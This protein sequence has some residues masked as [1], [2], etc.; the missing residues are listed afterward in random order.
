MHTL[1]RFFVFL[2]MGAKIV[3][4]DSP[5][6]QL[7]S[8]RHRTEWNW[9]EYRIA[10]KNT[11]SEI[12]FNPEIRYFA[13]DEMLSATVDY[14]TW[15]FPV[16]VEVAPIG[17]MSIIKLSV[18]AMMLPSDS[19][20]VHFR[21]YK[22]NWSAWN[23]SLD[24]SYQHNENKLE[25][26]YFMAVYDDGR[27]LLWGFDPLNGKKNSDAV[28]WSE[29][30]VN[31]VVQKYMGDT[32]E[33]VPAGRFWLFKDSPL[34]LKERLL[35]EQDGIVRYSVGRYQGK[36]LILFK[37][38]ADVR[39]SYLDRTLGHFYNVIPANDTTP[40]VVEMSGNGTEDTLSLNIGCWP[41]VDMKSC[42]DI[43]KKCGGTNIEYARNVVISGM[44]A[45]S[46]RCVENNRDVYFAMMPREGVLLNDKARGTINLADIQNS[47]EWKTALNEQWATVDWLKGVDYTGEG[48]L[49]GIY[50][51]GVD[52]SHPDFQELDSSGYPKERIM[53][54][55]EYYGFYPEKVRMINGKDDNWHGTSVAGV[56]G[57]NG[58]MS[59]N[60]VYRGVAP[61]VHFYAR[62]KNPYWLIGHVINRSLADDLFANGIY[63]R[64]CFFIDRAIFRN[65]KTDCLKA[66][67]SKPCIEG[68][69][70]AK[71][72]V[73]AAA[74]SGNF[75]GSHKQDLQR[76]YHS[77]LS[78]SKNAITVG[79]ITSREKVRFHNSSM[80]P[81]WDGRIKPDVMAPGATSEML[82]NE[83]HPFELMI[84]YVKLFRTGATAPYKVLDFKDNIFTEDLNNQL[85]SYHGIESAWGA[86]NG[87]VFKIGVN[88][89][90]YASLYSGWVFGG[91]VNVYPTDELEIRM[92]VSKGNVL[93]SMMYGNIILR[94]NDSTKTVRVVWNVKKSFVTTR[95]KL[96]SV[97][98]ILEA[99]SMRLD[100]GFVKGIISPYPCQD[101]GTC[102]YGYISDGGTS[103]SAPQVSG[104]A[105][106][107][108]QKFR[109]CT[110]EP[111]D[112][113][114]MRNSTVKSLIIHSAV[115]MEDSENAHF[116]C[117]PDIT[118]AHH[119][120]MCH[121]TPYG[122]GPDFATGW[123]RIDAAKALDAIGGYDR[124]AKEFSRFK[125]FEIG[126]GM[127][128]RWKVH[129]AGHPEK[130]R[131]TLV[132]DDAPGNLG[133]VTDSLNFLES[134]LVNDLDMYLV[135]P[136]G[137]YYYPWRLDPL[138]TD[139]IDANGNFTD[140]FSSGLENIKVQDVR[141]AY[142]DCNFSDKLD[143]RC[144]DH[145]NNV[146]VVDVENPESGSWQVVVR[147]TRISEGNNAN[148]DAQVA[149]IVSDFELKQSQCQIMHGYSAQSRYVCDYPFEK[150][151]A[152]YITFAESTF[153]G[154]GDTISLYDDKN[155]LLGKYTGNSLAGQ[156]FRVK[157]TR[158]KVVLDSDNDGVQG[159]GFGV[160]KI[161]SIPF[162]IL[163]MP[164]QFTNRTRQ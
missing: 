118:Y 13:K 139:F 39:K 136:S 115:D 55:F 162:A 90:N 48:I 8:E 105:A 161:E 50:D 131:V 156:K 124:K 81:T 7:L 157:A 150:Q 94:E 1:F 69:T 20:E 61:K 102:D 159:W 41:D 28:L 119:D 103:Q 56:I 26:H 71:T 133:V 17:G 45:D 63:L 49:V 57:G 135:S 27:H 160:S 92:K 23:S 93:N 152:N 146:E 101:D 60:H 21:I 16:T 79:N 62:D 82:V 96:N 84:D 19:L 3:F 25:R 151:N 33:F 47:E 78:N 116:S 85:S 164:L 121:F 144:F 142:N 42:I 153:V 15:L 12:I 109:E 52:F 91:I 22:E 134:K 59:D 30:G 74:N 112:K 99:L 154:S 88:G 34:S 114:S 89:A 64:D 43:V 66:P 128:R 97:Q 120:N 147:G 46:I 110:G 117:N 123:G 68:D 86:D 158:F 108:Y 155:G 87:Y 10:L 9:V 6:V 104:L 125:E 14:S 145:L 107:M 51:D 113:M 67:L 29:R 106:L 54:D 138:P 95:I 126:N 40:L 76:G 77:I 53:E 163:N 4:A 143:S 31:T 83:N 32:S 132:W 58:N 140:D 137:K 75:E 80:G 129:V 100:F 24:W 70:L 72:V 38:K 148:G 149:S 36:E 127:E 141:D 11:S 65:W 73:H 5:S 130:M 35:L 98:R 37:S 44:T 111:L 18:K 2:V 122:K